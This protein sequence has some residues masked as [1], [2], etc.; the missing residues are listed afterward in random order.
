MLLDEVCDIDRVI[1]VLG[2]ASGGGVARLHKSGLRFKHLVGGG[3]GEGEG[4]S[5]REGNGRRKG[6]ERGE[7]RG[8]VEMRG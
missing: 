7:M 6:E 1:F 3:K 5:D 4:C 2:V 8:A